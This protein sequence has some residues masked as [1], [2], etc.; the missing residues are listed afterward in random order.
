[1]VGNYILR[2]CHWT[3][4]FLLI[5][6]FS[7]FLSASA[8]E[9]ITELESITVTAERFPVKEKESPRFVTVVPF[10]ELKESGAN[11]LSDALKRV[12]GF[13]Y[14]A[15]A[16]LGISHGGMNSTLS[17][18]GI[19]DG[20]LIL[21]NGCPIQ[22]AAGHAYDLNTIPLDQ[23]E[24]VEILK[25]AASTLYGA[26]AMSGVINIITKKT[27]ATTAFTGS[28]EFGNNAYHNH[29]VGT[30]LPGINLGFNYQHLGSQEEISRSFS[31]KYR[32]DLDETDKY[33]WNLNAQLFDQLYFDYMGSY[34]TSA[35]EKHY[36][37]S[38]KPFEGTE[39]EHYKNFADFR[40]ESETFKGKLFG[41]YDEMQRNEYTDPD[42][43]DD[44]NKN[45]NAGL[46]GD[47]KFDLA[48]W[49]FNLGADW[50][51]RGANYN[52]QYGS[53]H[54]NDYSLFFQL[55]K[56]LLDSL[57]GTF[58]AREQFIDGASGAKDYDK[59][60]P[61][62]GLT[63]MATNT[64]NFFVNAGKAFRAPTFNNLY[65]DSSFL[66][67]NPDLD[68]EE[69][70]TYEGGLKYDL[71][72]LRLRLSLFYMA[73]EEKIEIDR[74]QG[75][76]LTYFNAGEYDSKGVEWEI[77]INPFTNQ[78]G[79]LQNISLYTSGY[80][81]DPTAED[82][83][84]ETYQTGP[85]LQTTVGLN[86]LTEPL[87]LDVNC[88]VVRSR[89]RNLD[90][91]AVL[92]FFSRYRLWKGYLTVAVDNIFDDDVQV[93]GDMSE[94]ASNQYLYYEVGRLVKVGYEIIF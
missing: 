74:S 13:D 50:V 42:E 77:G 20:E 87:T 5:S 56:N 18:R 14:K 33:A 27:Q 47:Y 54:R 23:I 76:P 29:S 59:F 24:R 22:G 46:E 75:Y 37:S 40:Y 48:G 4:L 17:I 57:T 15:F 11:N 61:S 85:K 51:Y 82:T 28:V 78:G 72:A 91:S 60:L 81:A 31:K 44:E 9:Q 26:D 68:P 1:M 49:N 41:S 88:N 35:F 89:E 8:E 62:V 63:Y 66:K 36:D 34:Y 45:Y 90:S 84:G 94:D 21:I 86:Y 73:Y 55:K 93:S 67:G 39:Q 53:H 92:N 64:L 83:A 70:W 30:S 6:L 38:D 69:G 58:G 7:G 79:E 80:W 52:N 12:G 43:P 25:G 71:N 3:L 32:Y 10:E 65:Y 16:P 19:K 2:T